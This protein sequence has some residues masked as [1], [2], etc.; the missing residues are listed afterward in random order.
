MGDIYLQ[1]GD[2]L[3]PMS[4][5][6][7]KTG[8]QIR[9]AK[10]VW[11]RRPKPPPKI[12]GHLDTSLEWVKVW[13]D[14]AVASGPPK[15][16]G[17]HHGGSSPDSYNRTIAVYALDGYSRFY[18]TVPVSLRWDV[19]GD[20]SQV[21]SCFVE[22]TYNQVDAKTPA[23]VTVR[24][25]APVG[26]GIYGISSP[27]VSNSSRVYEPVWFALSDAEV[28]AWPAS[29]PGDLTGR[30]FRLWTPQ[31]GGV[32]FPGV[33]W[34][35]AAYWGSVT[36]PVEEGNPYFAS[37]PHP[38]NVYTSRAIGVNGLTYIEIKN[39]FR[40]PFLGSGARAVEYTNIT[41]RLKNSSG[42]TLDELIEP[43]PI[44]HQSDH[45]GSSN[46]GV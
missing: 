35:N 11:L 22:M 15:I 33:C 43:G 19:L 1:V 9:E 26:W 10:Q 30:L 27:T 41:I 29:A 2:T 38:P 23:T 36:P 18:L 4:A 28:A 37:P 7:Y 14:P 34:D 5:F 46:P 8:G 40:M 12:I 6:A 39:D 42:G 20:T 24:W 25:D 32:F 31:K 21:A 16:Y 3:Q 44:V 13:E 45:Y 17:L